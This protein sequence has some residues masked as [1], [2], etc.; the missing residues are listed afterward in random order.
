[1]RATLSTVGRKFTLCLW[2]FK[3][4]QFSI[5]NLNFQ[6][7]SKSFN[8]R[9]LS[10]LRFRHNF[11]I[12]RSFVNFWARHFIFCILGLLPC[13]ININFSK[14][15]KIFKLARPGF[16]KWWAESAPWQPGEKYPVANRVKLLKFEKILIYLKMLKL[17]KDWWHSC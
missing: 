14:R 2:S 12:L 13:N 15:V 6:F 9:N 5:F 8:F 3:I 16:P 4:F 1:M 7:L 11:S 17:L 10:M